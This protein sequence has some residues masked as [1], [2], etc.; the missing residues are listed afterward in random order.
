[1]TPSE[2]EHMSHINQDYQMPW[3]PMVMKW[4]FDPQEAQV[5]IDYASALSELE[6]HRDLLKVA[7]KRNRIA[8]RWMWIAFSANV[9]AAFLSIMKL[10]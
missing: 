6:K 5:R 8:G 10:I 4:L 3:A 7:M 9:I 2:L 1:M